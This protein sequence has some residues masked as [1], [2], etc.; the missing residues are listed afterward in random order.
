MDHGNPVRQEEREIQVVS[1]DDRRVPGAFPDLH[2]CTCQ[3]VGVYRVQFGG[4]LVIQDEV[5]IHGQGTGYGNPFFHA[6][7]KFRCPEIFT[8]LETDH[9][10]LAADYLTYLRLGAN[11]VL[12]EPEPDIFSDGKGI[13]QRRRLENHTVPVVAR[14][15]AMF[16]SGQRDIVDRDLTAVRRIEPDDKLQKNAFAGP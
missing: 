11:P 10:K 5:R 15:G 2:D 4:R 16:F 7:R 8:P 1:D 6:A 12:P 3:F 14:T 13:E 9:G